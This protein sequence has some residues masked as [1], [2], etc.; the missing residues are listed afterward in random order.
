[1]NPFDVFTPTPPLDEEE[2]LRLQS[3]RRYRYALRVAGWSC[4]TLAVAGTLTWIGRLI[5]QPS[6]RAPGTIAAF[7]LKYLAAISVMGVLSFAVSALAYPAMRRRGRAVREVVLEL[8][9]DRRPS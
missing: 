9:R 8:N 2:Q 1:M 5:A 7:G 6:G 3:A 4:R